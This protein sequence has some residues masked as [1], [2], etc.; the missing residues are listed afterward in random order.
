MRNILIIAERELAAYFAADPH[1]TAT[2][3][4]IIETEEAWTLG[5]ISPKPARTAAVPAKTEAAELT[6]AP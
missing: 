2:Q 1:L 6:A 5:V 3:R 4:N